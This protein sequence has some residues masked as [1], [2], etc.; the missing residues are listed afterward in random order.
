MT[1][2]SFVFEISLFSITGTKIIITISVSTFLKNIFH[3]LVFCQ[4]YLG[5]SI[6]H[7]FVILKKKMFLNLNHITFLYNVAWLLNT[8]Q[9]VNI[10][11]FQICGWKHISLLQG[12]SAVS[13]CCDTSGKKM[14]IVD[15]R[16]NDKKHD[17]PSGRPLVFPVCVA[18]RLF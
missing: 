2:T 1:K 10:K 13:L 9:Q 14:W 4:R 11:K 7:G 15:G 6:G 5:S 8:H 12:I 17:M 18:L 3:N 16:S